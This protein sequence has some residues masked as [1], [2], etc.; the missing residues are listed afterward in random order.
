MR[1]IV[2]SLFLFAITP[3]MFAAN[4]DTELASIANDAAHPLASLSVL[5]VRN[6]QIVYQRQFGQRY[7]DNM[8]LA[9]SR[10]ANESTLYRV[11]SISKLVTT[12]GVLKLVEDGKLALDTDVSVYLGYRLRN[13]HFPNNPI[14]LR[15]LLTHTSSLRDDAG[16][17][18]EAKLH[19][20]LQDVLLTERKHFGKGAMW[21]NNAKP[22][23]YFH[24]ANLPW[25]VIATIIEKV[26]GERFDRLMKRLILDPMQLRG[27]FHP[28][29]FSSRELDN[30]ATLYRKRSEQNGQEVWHPTGPWIAQV[31]DYSKH[32]PIPRADRDYRIGSNGSLFA[33]QGG[34]RIST[35]DL[36]KIMLMLMNDGKHG[37]QFILKKETLVMMFT[38]A[39]QYDGKNGNNYYGSRKAFFNAWGLGNQQ[40]LDLTGEH[41]GDRLIE[42][43]GF[44]GVGHQGDAWGLR[45]TLVFDRKKKHGMIFLSSGSGFNPETYRGK[46]SS[47]YRFE[48]L[49]LTALYRYAILETK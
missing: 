26:S 39:W 2:L 46:Y 42:D 17:Y 16:Y 33:P 49:I 45:G 37:D 38:R 30:L 36:G 9:N 22:G 27:G 10:P 15:M 32:A 18:W 20:D 41:S 29:D 5:A 44:T 6:G 19:V 48:E 7:I 35:A 40:F 23:D 24:Y 43:G 21:A 14:T 47:R 34:L 13:P 28:A 8:N 31:D 3:P 12:L 4:L 11:A 25:G 1:T